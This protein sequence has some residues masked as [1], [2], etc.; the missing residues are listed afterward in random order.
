MRRRSWAIAAAAI[1]LPATA[2]VGQGLFTSASYVTAA[3]YLAQSAVRR[4]E[5]V[6]AA[7]VLEIKKGFHV[8]SDQPALDYLIPTRLEL[9]TSAGLRL[10]AIQYPKP[11]TMKFAFSDT[12]LVVFEGRTIIEFTVTAPVAAALGSVALKGKVQVQACDDKACYAPARLDLALNVPVV[13]KGEAVRPTHAEVFE[14]SA[15]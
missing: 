15:R 12:P 6:R 10:G 11:R 1:A 5:T 2:A 14:T 3:S 9:E 8:N 13:A 4:G 7:V